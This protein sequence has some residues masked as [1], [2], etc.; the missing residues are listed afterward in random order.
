[1]GG[2]FQEEY[3]KRKKTDPRG[4]Y[5]QLLMATRRATFQM[6]TKEFSELL[7]RLGLRPYRVRPSGNSPGFGDGDHRGPRNEGQDRGPRPVPDDRDDRGPRG[8]D[9]KSRGRE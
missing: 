7:E 5:F 4:A 2:N 8:D 1:M 9:E 3:E 6:D